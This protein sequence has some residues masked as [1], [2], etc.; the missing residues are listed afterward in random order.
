MQKL[1]EH[2]RYYRRITPLTI[3]I[4]AHDVRDTSFSGIW[5]LSSPVSPQRTAWISE[6]FT[7]SNL[8][9][10]N[11]P[12]SRADIIRARSPRGTKAADKPPAARAGA[13][14]AA[15]ELFYERISRKALAARQP[16]LYKKK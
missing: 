9:S 4:E 12:P 5:Q 14:K 6:N 7:D 13:F 1:S 3:R 16:L 11:L 2:Y 8:K 15:R 10:R